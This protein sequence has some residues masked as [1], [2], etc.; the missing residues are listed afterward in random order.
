MAEPRWAF[1]RTTAFRVTLLHLMLTI[2]GTL[3]VGGGAWWATVG[4]AARQ[5][6]QE[7]ERPCGLR[8]C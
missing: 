1:A 3:L 5:A 6:A 4:F 2:A 8:V 7:V